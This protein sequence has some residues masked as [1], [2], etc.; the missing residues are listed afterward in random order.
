TK[1]GNAE[2]YSIRNIQVEGMPFQV[3]ERQNNIAVRIGDENKLVQG[4]KRIVLSYT[5]KHYQDY[6]QTYD[7]AYLNLL[8]TD[9]DTAVRK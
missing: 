3:D 4:K 1:S 2:G 8:G 7:Y 9:Y 5:L 6:D